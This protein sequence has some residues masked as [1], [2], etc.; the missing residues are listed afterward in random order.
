MADQLP[1]AD[2]RSVACFAGG[3]LQTSRVRYNFFSTF[4]S[5]FGTLL[6]LNLEGLASP[7]WIMRTLPSLKISQLLMGVGDSQYFL[8]CFSVA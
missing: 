3:A 8:C 6:L 4:G 7:W 2:R 1:L 5:T